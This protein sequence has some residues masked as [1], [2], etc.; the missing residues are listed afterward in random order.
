MRSRRSTGDERLE[1]PSE[2]VR[3]SRRRDEAAR[4]LHNLLHPTERR[5]DDGKAGVQGV[6]DGDAKSFR[7]IARV[8]ID[9][10]R[11]Q[12]VRY[13]AALTEHQDPIFESCPTDVAMHGLE[14]LQLRA[15][16]CAADRQQLPHGPIAKAAE[17]LEQQR[18]TLSGFHSGHVGDQH[19]LG[20][21][22][23]RGANG[24]PNRLSAGGGGV[25]IKRTVERLGGDA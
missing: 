24:L 9:V 23:E 18:V 25:E 3:V 10:G 21:R 2:R 11:R 15:A 8:A 6:N 5:D 20:F 1:G 12:E 19:G 22:A 14:I 13:V 7:D 16:L 17:R 4:G